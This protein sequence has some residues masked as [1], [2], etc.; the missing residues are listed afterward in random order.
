MER[1]ILIKA[2]AFVANE[3]NSLSLNHAMLHFSS[4]L[5]MSWMG[6]YLP[7]DGLNRFWGKRHLWMQWTAA[8]SLLIP[9]IFLLD[10]RWSI[11]P[12]F[13]ILI[14]VGATFGVADILLSTESD[15][16]PIPD[17]II[18]DV[19]AR[20]AEN[21][22]IRQPLPGAASCTWTDSCLFGVS[23]DEHQSTMR[24]AGMT[25]SASW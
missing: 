17:S 11:Q 9:A 10:G 3:R 2:P 16:G 7:R 14:S 1:D 22:A 23:I 21:K 6:D 8:L 5:W 20:L 18:N 19:C 25:T 13:A 15:F 12:V 4:P 24:S